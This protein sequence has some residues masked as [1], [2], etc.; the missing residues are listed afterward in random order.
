VHA[1]LLHR[2]KDSMTEPELDQSATEELG[3]QNT[4]L[5]AQMQRIRGF[6]VKSLAFPF[7][8]VV[9][10]QDVVYH[11]FKVLG[12]QVVGEQPLALIRI[13]PAE[14]ERAIKLDTTARRETIIKGGLEELLISGGGPVINVN[15][16]GELYCG[17]GITTNS[18]PMRTLFERHDGAAKYE[19]LRTQLLVR[20][21]DAIVPATIVERLSTAPAPTSDRTPPSDRKD[22]AS[23]VVYAM[24]VPRIRYVESLTARQLRE[25][26]RAAFDAENQ[27]ARTLAIA[28]RLHIVPG[29]KRKLPLGA[30]V[31]GDAIKEAKQEWGEG[32]ELPPGYTFVKEHDRG[33][34]R[35]GKVIGHTATKSQTS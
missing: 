1:M 17:L 15:N 28:R 6:G 33:D 11:N 9:P 2:S 21:F 25:Q 5:A 29:F 30:R 23:D 26:F 18:I 13:V 14:L 27:A 3:R 10:G 24:L 7:G 20:L 4:V 31:S 19:V 34:E 8:E 22:S 32:Y 35:A 12:E 16:K